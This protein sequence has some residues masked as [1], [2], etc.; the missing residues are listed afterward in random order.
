MYKLKIKQDYMKIYFHL[1]L[2]EPKTIKNI[3]ENLGLTTTSNQRL[4]TATVRVVGR[5]DNRERGNK[6]LQQF[7]SIYII[8]PTSRKITSG[9]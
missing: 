4:V 1:N 3:F 8:T 2:L 7:I 6:A 9:R 5:R